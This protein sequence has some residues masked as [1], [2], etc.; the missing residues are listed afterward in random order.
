MS[1]RCCTTEIR[2][3]IKWS[4]VR[5]IFSYSTSFPARAL[6]CLCKKGSRG[7]DWFSTVRSTF[8]SVLF[9]FPQ[10]ANTYK[11]LFSFT[12]IAKSIDRYIFLYK[13]VMNCLTLYGLE[14]D[15]S[16]IYQYPIDN[17]FHSLSCLFNIP[18]II[19]LLAT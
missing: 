14:T 1:S 17:H 4:F 7:N 2:Y 10:P 11:C 13:I 18:L 15:C 12:E 19:Y 9:R 6:I 16:I 5:F 8:L 3:C